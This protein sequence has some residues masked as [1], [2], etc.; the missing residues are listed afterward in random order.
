MI[1]SHL[2]G[3]LGNQMFQ[4][5]V[6]RAISISR[7]VPFRLDVQ[8][9]STYTLHNGYELDRVFD[10][11]VE[12]ANKKDIKNVLGWRAYPPIRRQLIFRHKLEKFRKKNILVDNQFSPWE[13]INNVPDNVYLMGN[14][15]TEK[16]FNEIQDDIRSDFSFKRP[17]LGFNAEISDLIGNSVSVSLHVRRGDIATNPASLAFHG[18]CSLDYYQRAIEYISNNI[19]N[20]TFFIFSDNIPWA[21]DHLQLKHKCYFVEGNNGSESYNDMHLMSL[22]QHHIIANSSFSWWGAWLNPNPNKIVVAP[23]VWVLADFDTSDIVPDT[24]V[25]L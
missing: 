2:I 13:Q 12:L 22:C 3:G 11:S 19:D 24:W 4:Y 17:C 9:F 16:Y 21:R 6:G 1:I 14:W 25:K 7:D 18:L 15:Q 20:P 23:K 5:A 8:D 10:V